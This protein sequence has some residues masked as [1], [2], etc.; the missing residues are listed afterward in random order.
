VHKRKASI[1]LILAAIAADVTWVGV[2]AAG[3]TTVAM[4]VERTDPGLDLIVPAQ[5]I[6]EK[7]AAGPERRV[8]EL[9]RRFIWTEGPV[10][11]QGS[12]LSRLEAIFASK[13]RNSLPDT[14]YL[15]FAEIPSNSIRK[16]KPRDG[17]SVFMQPSGYEGT[18]SFPGPD[19]GSNG[20]TLDSR[21]R[22]TVAG[23]AQR[24]VWRLEH[25]NPKAQRR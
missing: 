1:W 19:P 20:M 4:T 24:D 5:P 16:W 3:S 12:S 17:V 9:Q 8:A 11:I 6:L 10:W 7:V 18:D 21:G 13:H 25:I 22:L 2:I 14:G 15:L 23:H